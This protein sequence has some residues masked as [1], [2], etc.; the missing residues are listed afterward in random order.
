MQRVE[1][2]A[3]FNRILD[4]MGKSLDTELLPF[5]PD[6]EGESISSTGLDSLSVVEFMIYVDDIFS[7]PG[8]VSDAH[9]KTKQAITVGQAV[10][11]V[12]DNTA[13]SACPDSQDIDAH[14]PC[15]GL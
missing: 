9:A 1:V 4:N 15:V 5:K 14:M 2:I 12:I 10:D 3:V 6:A 13:L 7:I 8:E 11:Y